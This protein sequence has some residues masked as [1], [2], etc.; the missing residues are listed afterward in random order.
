MNTAFM[1][2][3]G[4]LNKEGTQI[5]FMGF[6]NKMEVRLGIVNYSKKIMITYLNK[7]E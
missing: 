7:Y 2:N 3:C 4:V 5:H 1:K 6:T